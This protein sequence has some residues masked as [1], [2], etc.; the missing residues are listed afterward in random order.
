MGAKTVG[1][2]NSWAWPYFQSMLP[3]ETCLDPNCTS[4]FVWSEGSGSGRG[5]GSGSGSGRGRHSDWMDAFP[6]KRV[7]VTTNGTSEASSETEAASDDVF[8]EGVVVCS[9]PHSG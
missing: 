9:E 4:R 7:T 8:V 1:L 6:P 5:S 3:S 2:T